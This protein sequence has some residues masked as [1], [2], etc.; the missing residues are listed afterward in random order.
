V[1]KGLKEQKYLNT[2]CET[3][4]LSRKACKNMTSAMI[5]SIHMLT[6]KKGRKSHGFTF[7]HTEINATNDFWE[8]IIG[9]L[10]R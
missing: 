9:F 2:C 7:F 10:Q 3:T 1:V 6:K 8:K 5:T 4:V